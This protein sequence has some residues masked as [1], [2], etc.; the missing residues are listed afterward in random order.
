M[1]RLSYQQGLI[2]CKLKDCFKITE[3]TV[4]DE[5]LGYRLLNLAE[6]NIEIFEGNLLSR[7]MVIDI[8]HF[9]LYNVFYVDNECLNYCLRMAVSVGIGGF[10]GIIV[11]L[12]PGSHGC[13][14]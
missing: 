2:S 5:K 14:V 10:V 3:V 12:A 11:V 7:C 8:K 1:R 9:I 13:S 4:I 6:K